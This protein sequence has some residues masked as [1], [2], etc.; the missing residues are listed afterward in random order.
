VRD[1]AD[2]PS[3][4]RVSRRIEHSHTLENTNR[5]RT[6]DHQCF[7]NSV[8]LFLSPPNTRHRHVMFRENRNRMKF[9]FFWQLTWE[10]RKPIEYMQRLCLD[11]KFYPSRS[12]F[13]CVSLLFPPY[14][15]FRFPKNTS[16]NS[17][18]VLP[19]CSPSEGSTRDKLP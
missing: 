19:S 18:Y 2:V 8:G 12:L 4:A 11:Y 6:C 5:R 13:S 10:E 7:L 15:Y 9:A 16:L 14:G 1:V 17:L 3:W